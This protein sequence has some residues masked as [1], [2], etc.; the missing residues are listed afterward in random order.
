M[1]NEPIKQETA[2]AR[3]KAQKQAILEQ[4]RQLPIIQ[5]ACQKADVSRPTLYRMR[6]S[7]EKFR[8]DI[9]EAIAEGVA[10]VNDMSESQLIALI[11]NRNF[12]AL[13]LWLRTHHAS[14]TNKIEIKAEVQ[15][16]APLTPEKEALIER[17][18]RLMARPSPEAP[19]GSPK[20]KNNK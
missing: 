13:Q 20:D 1:T 16:L 7:D 18:I 6:N 9:E 15:H 19:G 4:L 8:A 3:Q 10:F 14:Y 17:G 5:L 11:K 2:A 12:P